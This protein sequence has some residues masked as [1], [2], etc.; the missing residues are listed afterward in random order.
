M[1][2]NKPNELTLIY[3]SDKS[4][5]RKTR[6]YV[7]T[8]EGYAIKTLDLKRERLS[9]TQLAEIADKLDGT[10]SDL[11]DK[12]YADPKMKESVVDIRAQDALKLLANDPILINTPILIIGKHAYQFDSSNEFIQESASIR[13]VGENP[14]ANVQE[15]RDS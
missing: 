5:D 7:E 8:F 2:E 4:E 6:A 9:E 10:I 14:G 3:H 1:I 12:T 13:G 11:I 15:K